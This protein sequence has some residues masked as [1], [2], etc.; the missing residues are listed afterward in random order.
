[1]IGS[2]MPALRGVRAVRMWAGIMGFTPDGAP[3]FGEEPAAP[4]LITAAGFTG[5]GLPFAAAVGEAVACLIA[6]GRTPLPLA[7]LSSRR[8]AVPAA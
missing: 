2:I 3:I 5:N 4:G 8:F 6:E 1:V 7:P